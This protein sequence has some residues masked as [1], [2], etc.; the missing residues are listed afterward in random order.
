MIKSTSYIS[1]LTILRANENDLKDIWQWRN[2]EVTR[3][4]AITKNSVSLEEHSRWYEKSLSNPNHYLYVGYLNNNEKI[5][6]CWFDI[7]TKNNTADVSINLNPQQRG[8]NLS[9]RLLVKCLKDFWKHEKR[10]LTSTIK[11]ANIASIR[12]F[13][14]ADF[15]LE[16]ENGK[17]CHYIKKPPQ[18]SHSGV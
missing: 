4:M 12:C 15:V 13:T 16:K 17:Y 9:S 18:N 7:N 1:D 2:D 14:K 8:K 11:K 5:G 6:I 3:Q 10:D